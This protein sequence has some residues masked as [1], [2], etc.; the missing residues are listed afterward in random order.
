MTSGGIHRYLKLLQPLGF[1]FFLLF[2]L[3]S[4]RIPLFYTGLVLTIAGM[5]YELYNGLTNG[6]KSPSFRKGSF[7]TG[8]VL[9]LFLITAIS[10]RVLSE[11]RYS[12]ILLLLAVVLA[13]VWNIWSNFFSSG[14]SR[15]T[16]DDILDG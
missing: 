13:F 7:L 11:N 3:L 1:A 12:L 2:F 8:F 6:H 15:Q 14:K 4:N 16:D 9:K 5:A 10:W